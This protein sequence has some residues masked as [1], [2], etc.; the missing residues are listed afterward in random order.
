MCGED[1]ATGENYD[2][3]KQ[4]I[5]SRLRF[6]S[7]VYAI[8][9]CAYAVMSNHYHVVLHVDEGRA[10]GWSK[11]EVVERWMQLYKGNVLVDRWLKNPDAM[12]NASMA[13]VDELIDMWRERLCSISWF[14]R[15][16]NETIARMAN[17]EENCKGRFWEGRFKSQAL[18]DEAAVLSCMAYVDL[19]PIRAGM[20]SNLNESDFTSIQQRLFDFAKRKRQVKPHSAITKCISK[21]ERLK[22]ALGVEKQPEAPLM[23]FDG[24]SHTD[25]HRALPFTQEDYFTLLDATG[26]A[27]REDK[28]GYIPSDVPSIVSQYG[29]D[30]NK[31]LAHVQ[32]FG[33]TY[34]ICVGSADKI[35]EY[36]HIFQRRWAKGVGAA[37]DVYVA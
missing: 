3:R 19:N 25:I 35:V 18:L 11:E 31:W 37:Q 20:E 13:A 2:H 14:M 1:Y 9:I 21:Q 12:D 26:R 33:C 6:L 22:A 29:I 5:V 24:S 17:E 10:K 36:A 16:V 27:F 34:S 4:W 8:D 32:G 30:P 7:Y 15:G 23:R 28:R